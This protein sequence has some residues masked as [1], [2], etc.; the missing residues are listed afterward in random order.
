MMV[1][2]VVIDLFKTMQ[3]IF[4]FIW[5]Y[6]LENHNPLVEKIRFKICLVVQ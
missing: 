4:Q 6:R 3:I 5:P 2:N 1:G